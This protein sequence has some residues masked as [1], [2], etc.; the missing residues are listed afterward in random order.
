M[1]AAFCIAEV[2]TGI[3]TPE[4]AVVA[5]GGAGAETAAADARARREKVEA[6][7]VDME[8]SLRWLPAGRPFQGVA[9]GSVICIP[10][11]LTRP[12]C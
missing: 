8:R 4:V 9:R 1:V 3:G 11:S 6:D 5:E 7:F 10:G 2:A 12:S